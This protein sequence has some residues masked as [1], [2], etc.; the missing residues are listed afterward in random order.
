VG[1]LA[2]PPVS[3]GLQDTLYEA[4][5]KFLR[6][7]YGQIPIEDPVQGVVGML[8]LEELMEAYHREIQRLKQE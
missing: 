6:S 3:A 1:E 7:G 4:L 2:S 5:L 8:R